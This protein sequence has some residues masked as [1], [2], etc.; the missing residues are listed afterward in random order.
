MFFLLTVAS[1]FFTVAVR[2]YRLWNL[3]REDKKQVIDNFKK[4]KRYE[5]KTKTNN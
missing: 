4:V 3:N 1:I 5:Q 2:T